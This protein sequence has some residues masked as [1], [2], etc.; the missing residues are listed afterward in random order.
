MAGVGEIDLRAPKAAVKIN[1]ERPTGI[2]EVDEL[3]GMIAV[4][5][6]FVGRRRHLVHD[7]PAHTRYSSARQSLMARLMASGAMLSPAARAARAVNSASGAK[8]RA[9]IC[10][11]LRRASSGLPVSR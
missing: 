6:P 10:F 5:E 9:T 3:A 7:A 8:R 2:A 4:S 11:T 1:R